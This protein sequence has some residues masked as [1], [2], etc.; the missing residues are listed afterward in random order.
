M[1]SFWTFHGSL[2][3]PY[4]LTEHL[5]PLWTF[6]GLLVDPVDLSRSFVDPHDPCMDSC[7]TS[8]GPLAPC[9]T[10]WTFRGLFVSAT[11]HVLVLFV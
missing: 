3:D 5:W 6:H 4:G 8:S 10:L 11:L 1:D 9:G 7:W 2:V